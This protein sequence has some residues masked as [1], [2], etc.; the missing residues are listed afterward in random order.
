MG[1]INYNSIYKIYTFNYTFH[2]RVA[3]PGLQIRGWGGGKGGRSSRPGGTV[4][5]K[6]FFRPFG[7]Q[8]GLKIGGGEAPPLDPP[9]YIMFFRS[10]KALLFLV[11]GQVTP[12]NL[13]QVL[14]V[15]K[16]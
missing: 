5:K 16:H 8:F 10:I 12:T 7:P 9:L 11:I 1:L 14:H 13:V 6:I 2:Y 15:S 4:S 3:D